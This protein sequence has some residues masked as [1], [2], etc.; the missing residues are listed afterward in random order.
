M[1]SFPQRAREI[2]FEIDGRDAGEELE[3]EAREGDSGLPQIKYHF[4]QMTFRIEECKVINRGIIFHE[5]ADQ[6]QSNMNLHD[7]PPTRVASIAERP[8]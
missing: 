3:K 2:E 4:A 6:R 8:A 5:N 1:R 7:C